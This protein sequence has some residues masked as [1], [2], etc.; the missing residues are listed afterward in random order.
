MFAFRL[1]PRWMAGV[2]RRFA[3]SED[4]EL[5]GGRRAAQ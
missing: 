3:L 4:A 5:V 2:S 1:S